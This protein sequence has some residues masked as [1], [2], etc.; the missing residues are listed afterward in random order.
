MG[1]DLTAAY[2]VT[3]Y[4]PPRVVAIRSTSGP[5]PII[6]RRVVEAHSDGAR[7]TETSSGGPGGIARVLA[8]LMRVVLRRTIARDY[9][10]LKELLEQRG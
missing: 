2:E 10:H 4:D 8:P 3:E 5:F 7:V 9:R 1:R 6:V